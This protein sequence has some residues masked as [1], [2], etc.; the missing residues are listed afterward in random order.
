MDIAET[1][2]KSNILIIIH[3]DLREIIYSIGAMAAIRRHHKDEHIILLT[4]EVFAELLKDTPHTDEIWIDDFLDFWEIRKGREFINR[5]RNSNFSMIYDLQKSRRTNWYFRLIGKQKPQWSGNISWCSHPYIDLNIN[6]IN[7]SE[8]YSRQLKIAEINRVA[9]TNISFINSDL[10]RLE[11]DKNIDKNGFAIIEP[12]GVLGFPEKQWYE[13]G[14]ID[15]M[16]WLNENKIMPVI[17]GFDSDA[18]LI[19]SILQECG[20]RKIKL[21]DLTSSLDLEDIV[22]L[23]RL[24]RFAIGNETG[25]MHMIAATN[26]PTIMLFSAFSGV[27]QHAPRSSNVSI[28]EEPD[29]NNLESENVIFVIEQKL[30][31]TI[32]LD[33]SE[34]ISKPPM[35]DGE[36]DTQQSKQKNKSD[37]PV[38][39]EDN[40]SK[41]H[42][43]K[44]IAL[45][46]KIG[47]KFIADADNNPK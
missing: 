25:L 15:I 14:F 20:I 19:D 9:K 29:L 47:D 24:S 34:N 39:K 16:E 10:S 18:I 46:E 45:Q 44:T 27:D 6:K 5:L 1:S 35:S 28:I 2:S 17:I 11:L 38:W 22:E 8:T 12:G 7:I 31:I 21:W 4:S 42:S 26:I 32:K 43:E 36:A 40:D 23:S 41:A 13:E 3:G 37:F 30:K 33:S